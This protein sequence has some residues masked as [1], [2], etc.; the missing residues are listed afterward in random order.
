MVWSWWLPHL[1]SFVQSTS[2]GF[3]YH[4]VY[5]QS[6]SWVH[7]LNVLP[8]AKFDVK[9]SGHTMTAHSSPSACVAEL[10]Q[11]PMVHLLYFRVYE[12]CLFRQARASY[13]KPG[14]YTHLIDCNWYPRIIMNHH[15]SVV[16]TYCMFWKCSL[17]VSPIVQR[18]H[19]DCL[20]CLEYQGF[21]CFRGFQLFFQWA[22][23]HVLDCCCLLLA[24]YPWAGL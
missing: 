9:I 3:H 18:H 1:I 5:R 24:V 8:S 16:C 14:S 19:W 12:L 22:W 20:C 10:P 13:I 23:Q 4:G 6:S 21:S 11:H 7:V 17:M 2:L 15:H